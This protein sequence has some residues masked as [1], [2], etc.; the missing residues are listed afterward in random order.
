MAAEI[1][2]DTSMVV[3]S[4]CAKLERDIASAAIKIPIAPSMPSNKVKSR[5]NPAG[6]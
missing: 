3:K 2:H 4:I 5:R 6:R 1:R